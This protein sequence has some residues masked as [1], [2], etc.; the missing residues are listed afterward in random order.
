MTAVEDLRC[1]A[2]I[3]E[4]QAARSRTFI[5]AFEALYQAM[6]AAQQV[7]ADRVFRAIASKSTD[8]TD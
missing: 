3:A 8:D 7:H 6:T 4:A 2:A 5:P 1:F